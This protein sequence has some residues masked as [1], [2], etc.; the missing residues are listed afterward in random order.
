MS[1]FSVPV[2]QMGFEMYLDILY[3]QPALVE[4]LLK[5]NEAFAVEWANAQLEAGATAIC[6]FDPLSSPTVIP[7]DMFL[8]Y[9][10]PVATRVM[11]QIKG[12]TATHLASGR[13]IPIIDEFRKTG[14][15]VISSSIMEDISAMKEACK[16]NLTVLGNLNGIEMVRWTDEQAREI[17]KETIRKAA[18]GGGFILS[19]NHGEIPYHVSDHTLEVIMDTARTH[20]TY[21]IK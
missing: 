19:D 6:Y 16:G 13:S 4:H 7:M 1:P 10:L 17:V 15:A 14:T 3:E 8:H 9:G 12:P 20:G 5:V 2:M 21:P 18:P 11:Q